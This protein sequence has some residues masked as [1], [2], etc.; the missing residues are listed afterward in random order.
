M[1]LT[2]QHH[3]ICQCTKEQKEDSE[4]AELNHGPIELQSIALPLS[5]LRADCCEARKC[6]II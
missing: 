5:Y 1:Q 4:D 3:M 2:S 6:H